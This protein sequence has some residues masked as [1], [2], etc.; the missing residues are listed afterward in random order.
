MWIHLIKSSLRRRNHITIIDGFRIH[1][2]FIIPHMALN[3]KTPAEVAK[4]SLRL[5]ESK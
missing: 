4:V 1:Y 5:K 2:N 3:E